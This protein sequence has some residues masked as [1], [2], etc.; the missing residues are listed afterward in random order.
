MSSF[1]IDPADLASLDYNGDLIL[2]LGPHKTG[3]T[4][5]QAALARQ[6]DALSQRRILY[7]YAGRGQ[8]GDNQ[9]WMFGETLDNGMLAELNAIL[10][11]LQ[12]EI[13]ASQPDTVIIS[14]ER[15]AR[16]SIP[17]ETFSLIAHIFPNAKVKIV[18]ALRRQDKL[19]MSRYAEILKR[20][21]QG[22][23]LQ[24]LNAP[25]YLDHLRRIAE[26][27][28]ALP[29]ADILLLPYERFS[30]D[31]VTAF[32]KVLGLGSPA[33]EAKPS[34]E[35]RRLPWRAT[36]T[37]ALVN[38]LPLSIAKPL[39]GRVIDFYRKHPKFWR[40]E[41]PLSAEETHHLLSVYSP[42]N[43]AIEA[44]FFDGT[45]IGLGA[46]AGPEADEL[47]ESH[48]ELKRRVSGCSLTESIASGA[49]N[50]GL[51]AAN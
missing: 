44:L 49:L 46:S 35:N 18:L 50:Q 5:I 40:S 47:I 22:D 41:P 29:D 6:A 24:K 31:V 26:L 3:T 45:D 27:N 42:S 4:A 48:R 12:R 16:E 39:R 23:T 7:P 51:T 2:H 1:S 32:F 34:E 15:L 8:G 14:T 36:K 19:L 28:K 30:A 9:H 13:D 43:R 11:N 20:G 10:G 37:L 33:D 21:G 17:E 38:K 25:L